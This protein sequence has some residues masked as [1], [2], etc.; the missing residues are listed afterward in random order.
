MTSYN[1]D[2]DAAPLDELLLLLVPTGDPSYPITVEIGSWDER[3]QR[4][5][6]SWRW[7]DEDEEG[8][9]PNSD[10]IAWRE[11]PEIDPE[12]AASFVARRDRKAAHA[13]GAPI[14]SPN[15]NHGAYP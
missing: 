8:N 4:F 10:P 11:I 14:G 3:Q 9:Y 1:R 12:I 15:P 2:M 5:V 6:G 7:Y 13:Y